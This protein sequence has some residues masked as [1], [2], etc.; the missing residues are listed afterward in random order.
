MARPQQRPKLYGSGL[1]E[2]GYE[3]IETVPEHRDDDPS[4]KSPRVIP[5]SEYDNSH[6]NQRLQQVQEAELRNEGGRSS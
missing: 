5:A 6:V 1:E 3:Q 2:M 4:A